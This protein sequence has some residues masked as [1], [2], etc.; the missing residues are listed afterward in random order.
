LIDLIVGVLMP[1]STHCIISRQTVLLEETD[2]TEK[3][4][5]RRVTSK[6]RQPFFLQT[7]DDV[8]I[9]SPRRNG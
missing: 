1:L 8:I 6:L 3:P 7:T 2:Y 9:I 5:L 4:I